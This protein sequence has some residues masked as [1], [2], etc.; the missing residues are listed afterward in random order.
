MGSKVIKVRTLVR[1][2]KP[3]IVHRT[4]YRDDADELRQRDRA[5][6]A[7][8]KRRMAAQGERVARRFE[9]N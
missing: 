3:D 6:A 9:N 2:A 7:Q 1:E 5:R 4:I 8:R